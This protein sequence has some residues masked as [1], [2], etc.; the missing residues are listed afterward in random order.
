MPESLLISVAFAAAG[1][2][3]KGLVARAR[4]Y[5]LGPEDE[6]A[7]RGMFE[8]ALCVALEETAGDVDQETVYVMESVSR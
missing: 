3:V 1:T 4:G 8:R 6:G 7:L 5:V 2:L